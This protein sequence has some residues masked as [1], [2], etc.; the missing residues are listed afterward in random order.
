MSFSII[1]ALGANNEIGLHNDLLWYIPGDLKRFKEI[2]TGHTIVMGKNTYLSLP[3]RPLPNRRN[4]VI[5]RSGASFDGVETLAS[6]QEA[7]EACNPN[8]E[9]FIIGGGSIY[10]QFMP[11]TDKLYLTRVYENTEADVFF[12]EIDF[13]EWEMIKEE[14]HLDKKPPFSYQVFARKN[15]FDN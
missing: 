6:I 8:E 11:F 13:N 15:K 2:T 14:K 4:I 10:K 5:T 3:N 1:V 7:I 9:N 12:P